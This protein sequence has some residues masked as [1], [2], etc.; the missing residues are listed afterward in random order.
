MTAA[1]R[2]LGRGLEA[3]LGPSTTED[4]VQ[5]GDL[6]HVPLDDIGPNPFQPRHVFDEQAITDLANSLRTSGLLQ[7]VVLRPTEAGKYQL[8]AG[9]RRWRAA[10]QLGWGEIGAVV[11]EVDDRT[12]L[13][14]AQKSSLPWWTRHCS[15]GLSLDQ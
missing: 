4:A 6:R 2:R 8:I 11:R 13:S 5:S 3:L 9:E 1:K 12:L 15:G 14:R 10:Q 7:P